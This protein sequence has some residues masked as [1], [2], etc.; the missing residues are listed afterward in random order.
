ML[1]KIIKNVNLDEQDVETISQIALYQ[2]FMSPLKV[3]DQ[4]FQKLKT[5]MLKNHESI[6]KRIDRKSSQNLIMAYS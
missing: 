6:L 5:Y 1:F 3:R 2:K 4:F